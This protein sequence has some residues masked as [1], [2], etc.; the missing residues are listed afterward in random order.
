MPHLILAAAF[1]FTEL[2]ILNPHQE[3]GMPP[4]TITCKT[5]A[6]RQ[7]YERTIA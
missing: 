1:W 5:D 6:E 4:L 7:A 3:A 2:V